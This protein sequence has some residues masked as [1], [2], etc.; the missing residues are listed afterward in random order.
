V[1]HPSV[2]VQDKTPSR[3]V[4][5]HA[6]LASRRTALAAVVIP[7]SNAEPMPPSRPS[8]RLVI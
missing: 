8:L 7:I 6:E 4:G 2:D 3:N 1:H 5:V